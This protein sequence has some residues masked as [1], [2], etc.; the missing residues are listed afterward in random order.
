M[1]LCTRAGEHN[2][3][4]V[5]KPYGHVLYIWVENGKGKF[6]GQTARQRGTIGHVDHGKTT[7]TAITTVLAAKFGGQGYDQIDAALEKIAA[8]PSTPPTLSTRRNRH[9]AHVDC[10]TTP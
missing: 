8:S 3:A 10:Q 5:K 1:C 4:D 7:L 6:D 2:S 9:Y